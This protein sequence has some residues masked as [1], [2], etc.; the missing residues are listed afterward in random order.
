MYGLDNVSGSINGSFV[1]SGR[2]A[3]MN[4]I[5]QDLDGNISFALADGEWQ[6]TDI[7]YE[8]RKAR[9]TLKQEPAPEPRLPPRTE[10]TSVAASGV[11]TNG[12]LQNDDLIVELPFLRLTGGGKVNFV[13]A[14]LD[15]KMDA[16]VVESPELAGE[17]SAAELKDFT[18]ANIP[19][20][21]SGPLASPSIAPDFELMLKREVKKQIDKEKDKLI[22]RLLG[23]K[24]EPAE[25]EQAEGE[26]QEEGPEEQD[27]EQKAEDLIKDALKN[28]F[29]D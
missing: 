11:V 24:K 19:L 10:F 1:L 22:D 6:G 20:K 27:E 16:R 21:I 5:R 14:T 4:A 23:I 25:G 28:L 8:I 3:D 15:Y 26:P 2:G 9:A 13:E 12:V 7:W 29:K 18:S 17:L